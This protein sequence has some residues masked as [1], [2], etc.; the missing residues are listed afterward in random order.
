MRILL[1]F[2]YWQPFGTRKWDLEGLAKSNFSFIPIFQPKQFFASLALIVLFWCVRVSLQ[3][4]SPLKNDHHHF[5]VWVCVRHTIQLL[6]FF[7]RKLTFIFLTTH[8]LRHFKSSIYLTLSLMST[9]KQTIEAD[10][11]YKN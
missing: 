3:Y 7:L 9:I 4:G 2:L 1:R 5:L 11:F 6:F 8:F 10:C